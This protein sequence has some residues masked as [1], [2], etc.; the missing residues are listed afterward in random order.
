M[1]LTAGNFMLNFILAGSLSSLWQMIESQQLVVIL[2][3]FNVIMPAN[4]AQIFNVLMQIAAFDPIPAEDTIGVWL[5]LEET[6]PYKND[7]ELMGFESFF[8]LFNLG[9]QALTITLVLLFL[10]L[11]WPFYCNRKR[12]ETINRCQKRMNKT[13]KYKFF[14]RLMRE[15]YIII[16]I[17]A[18]INLYYLKWDTY[19]Q[20]LN[21]LTSL[22][23]ISVTGLYPIWVYCILSGTTNWH[24]LQFER[25]FGT[26]FMD[27]RK[28]G[29]TK[30]QLSRFSM[31]FY[32]RRLLIVV[33]LMWFQGFLVVQFFIYIKLLIVNVILLLYIKPYTTKG[34]NLMETINEVVAM[35]IMYHM[36]MFTDFVPDPTTRFQLGFSCIVFIAVHL[37]M[38]LSVIIVGSIKHTKNRCRVRQALKKAKS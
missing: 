20:V 6:G 38:N 24:R 31:F 29:A 13:F 23:T 3:L 14:L 35:L 17:C 19:G 25:K 26:L 18:L 34:Q 2:P 10:L 15:L 9:T 11:N 30:K 1:S 4:A 16:L 27:L 33:S 21:S 8:C 22:A 5:D 37:L 12:S 28:K 36:F 32:L 7:F